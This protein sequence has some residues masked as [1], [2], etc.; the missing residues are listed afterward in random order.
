MSVV[1]VGWYNPGVDDDAYVNV[2]GCLRYV[3][4]KYGVFSLIV[5][6]EDAL[7]TV[8][9]MSPSLILWFPWRLYSYMQSIIH[10]PEFK[11][12]L[13]VYNWDDPY[14]WEH[15]SQIIQSIPRD[16]ICWSSATR[17]SSAYFHT[18]VW[19]PPPIVP[20]TEVIRAQQWFDLSTR[21]LQCDIESLRTQVQDR[22]L[23]PLTA[24]Y[25]SR[26]L[27]IVHLVRASPIQVV[28]MGSTAYEWQCTL[29]ECG[30]DAEAADVDWIVT[31]K[32]ILFLPN[33]PWAVTLSV[34]SHVKAVINV[35]PCKSDYTYI[36]ERSMMAIAAETRL[37]GD[38]QLLIIKDE[39]KMGVS[40]IQDMQNPESVTKAIENLSYIGKLKVPYRW[41]VEY[42]ANSLKIYSK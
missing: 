2:L 42:W 3:L 12:K 5:R 26:A 15:E 35:H 30:Y 32:K 23:L 19:V 28:C 13:I 21:Q 22:L 40:I 16:V 36:N 37:L 1:I 31:N 25:P 29:E 9:C 39:I 27:D 38:S 8:R 11:K 18:H 6:P 4:S 20:L 34:M 17:Q 41:T 33:S 14:C 24:M 10:V 7:D